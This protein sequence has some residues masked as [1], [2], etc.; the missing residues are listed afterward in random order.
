MSRNLT[1]FS[2]ALLI[3]VTDTAVENETI[4]RVSCELEPVGSEQHAL[5]LILKASSVLALQRA[6]DDMIAEEEV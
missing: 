5:L 3:N 6:N 4:E 2:G 1:D